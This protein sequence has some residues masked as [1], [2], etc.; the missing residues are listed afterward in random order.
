VFEQE[1]QDFPGF[2]EEKK[3]KDSGEFVQKLRILHITIAPAPAFSPCRPLSATRKMS[4]AEQFPQISN[5]EFGSFVDVANLGFLPLTIGKVA[6]VSG[7]H[8]RFKLSAKC[9]F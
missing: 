6:I 4:D 8:P 5:D 1:I 2:C 7:C 3:Q 9:F